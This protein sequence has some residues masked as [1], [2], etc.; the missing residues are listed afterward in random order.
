M[1]LDVD[2]L[3]PTATQDMRDLSNPNAPIGYCYEHLQNL[4]LLPDTFE[5]FFK[6]G[7]D[8]LTFP[9]LSRIS[10]FWFRMGKTESNLD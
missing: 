1:E 7:I 5:I 4:G 2:W 10:S 9:V 3:D 6:R 8:A